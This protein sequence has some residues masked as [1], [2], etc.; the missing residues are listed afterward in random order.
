MRACLE[1]KCDRDVLKT[2]ELERKPVALSLIDF[3]RAHVPLFSN[4]DHLRD[5]AKPSPKTLCRC[6]NAYIEALSE[7]TGINIQY[8][9]NALVAA[10]ESGDSGLA[11]NVTIGQRL[12]NVKLINQSDG[13]MVRLHKL[14][15][16]DGKFRL[17]VFP[18]DLSRKPDADR[19]YELGQELTS[20]SQGKVIGRLIGRQLDVITVHAGKR[21]DIELLDLHEAF[22]PWSDEGW[23]Y[24]KV[25][26]DGLARLEGPCSV[27]ETLGIGED[28]CMI[29]LRPDGYVSMIS[30]M[31]EV[32][33][34][35][36]F[37]A[38]L[39]KAVLRQ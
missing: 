10:A 20:L 38:G 37:L 12:R 17:L 23:D 6:Q 21:L 11:R 28:G 26:V 19:F 32:D 14:I 24:W 8:Q 2:Y 3:D 25:Y 16:P 34:V 4:K 15:K 18:G 35:G 22:H 7:S 29:L 30:G 33:R 5:N 13:V 1:H 36:N 9:T 31:S 39:F 27:Y